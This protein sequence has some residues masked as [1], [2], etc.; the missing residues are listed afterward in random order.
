M[1]RLVL[2]LSFLYFFPTVIPAQ[3]LTGMWSGYLQTPETRLDYEMA[4]Y[5]NGK[6]M[7]GYSCIIYEKDGVE[8]IGVKTM[9]LRYKKNNIYFE[10]GEL[11][12]D[13]FTMQ[14]RRVKMKGTL[15]VNIKNSQVTLSGAFNT[16]SLDFRDARTYSGEIYL[17]K[18]GNADAASAKMIP[19]LSE[20]NL[21]NTLTFTRIERNIDN[22]ASIVPVEPVIVNA[23]HSPAKTDSTVIQTSE[24]I[25]NLNAAK[26]DR[27]TEII[28]TVNFSS[29]SLLLSLV[30]NGTVDGDSISLVLN[31]RIILEKLGLT[32]RS[33][34]M[35]VPVTASPGDSLLLIMYAESLGSIPPNSGLLIIQDGNTRHEIRFEGDLQRSS[36]VMLRK[37]SK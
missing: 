24:Q 4:I 19:V 27:K 28:R 23:H 18:K 5:N 8:N 29:D 26:L 22:T 2:Y 30:D 32:G 13:N 33:Y 9:K 10:D 12:Y 11:V 3:D 6:N 37:I 34:R 7:S 17:Q 20:K 21:L 14:S 36:G 25:A 1:Q 35:M 15:T 16:R 31:G